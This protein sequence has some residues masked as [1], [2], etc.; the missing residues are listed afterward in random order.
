MH[1]AQYREHYRVFVNTKL[2]VPEKSGE[3]LD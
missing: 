2:S 1:L 3:F